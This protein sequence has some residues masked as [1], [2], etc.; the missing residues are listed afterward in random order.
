[1]ILIFESTSENVIKNRR[2]KKIFLYNTSVFISVYTLY[3]CTVFIDVLKFFPPDTLGSTFL[4]QGYP[5]VFEF[6]I[7]PVYCMG[8]HR[9]G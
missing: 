3:S 2:L 6:Q 1:M 5:K 8:V 9:E 4:H 7:S